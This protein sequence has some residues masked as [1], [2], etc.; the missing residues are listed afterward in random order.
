MRDLIVVEGIL[1]RVDDILAV[2]LQ[3]VV[4]ALAEVRT[5]TGV[6]HREAAA[7]VD[8]F[9][10]GAF[11]HEVGVVAAHFVDAT[12]NVLDVWN[13]R[14]E[15]A[16][17]QLQAMQHVLGLER[18]D[19]ID[20]L[21]RGQAKHAAVAAGAVPVAADTDAGLDAHTD[22][23]LD[24]HLATT[25]NDDRN[26]GGRFD[27]EHAG[28][29]KFDRGQAEI[30]ELLVLVAVA[31]DQAAGLFE[32]RQCNDDLRLAAHFE[33]V[34]VARAERGD[35][36]DDLRLLVDLDRVYP[37]VF[38]LVAERV[39]GLAEGCV[40]AMNLRVEDVLDAEQQRH[41]QVAVER[42]L[43]DVEQLDLRMQC[44]RGDVAVLRYAEVVV[45]PALKTVELPGFFDGPLNLFDCVQWFTSSTGLGLWEARFYRVGRVNLPL[46]CLNNS[47]TKSPSKTL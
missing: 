2:F 19:K 1:E 28:K 39:D 14:A 5:P 40:Q 46:S 30:N 29:T 10:R 12:A 23:R 37:A 43:D 15:M 22:D 41:L 34:L 21:R 27:D 8:V 18:V 35:L 32:R 11:L 44:A 13:L 25:G 33:A 7:K 26:L 47:L 3:G 38:A 16:M 20:K 42:A 31:D 6:V 24:A 4:A 36:F 45:A 17:E 9:Q